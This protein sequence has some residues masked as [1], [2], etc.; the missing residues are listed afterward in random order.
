M[1]RP[2]AFA[3]LITA[4]LLVCSFARAAETQPASE[5]E[6]QKLAGEVYRIFEAKCADC[7]GSH[8]PKPKGKFG[9]VLDLARVAKN[10]EYVEPG[11]P[12]K[13]DIYQ[14]V[15]HKEMPGEDADVPP[16]TSEEL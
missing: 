15:L 14:M 13:S 4:L 7:H 9:Y 1:T 11:N 10:P 2:R 12:A 16:L 8:L 5:A 6:K 3:L